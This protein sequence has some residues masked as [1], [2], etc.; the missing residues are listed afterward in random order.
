[1]KDKNSERKTAIDLG[2]P[3]E[4]VQRYTVKLPP[5]HR[6]G[7]I[8]AEQAVVPSMRATPEV[9]EAPRHSTVPPAAA[10]EASTAGTARAA[11]QSSCVTF[12]NC[13]WTCHVEQR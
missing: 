12:R 9:T 2:E 5:T 1:M 13:S 4:S 11:R 6:F 8:P 7:G 10:G 3:F